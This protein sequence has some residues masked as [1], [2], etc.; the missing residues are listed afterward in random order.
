MLFQQLDLSHNEELMSI[1]N[2]ILGDVK[3]RGLIKRKN[4][5]K[6]QSLWR[7]SEAKLQEAMNKIPGGFSCHSLKDEPHTDRLIGLVTEEFENNTDLA[8]KEVILQGKAFYP[9]G[10][11]M[12]WHNDNSEPGY[13]LYCTYAEEDDKSFIRY[14]NTDTGKVETAW[15]KKGWYFRVFDINP[16]NPLWHCV[17]SDTVRFSIGHRFIRTDL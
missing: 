17:F 6:E 8:Y 11:F 15:D 16:E 10:S 1:L 14:R 7:V 12:S 9:P 2:D 5:T 4:F 3:A 13:V